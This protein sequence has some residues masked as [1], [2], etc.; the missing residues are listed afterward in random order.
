DEDETVTV[1]TGKVEIGQGIKTALAQIAAEE[2]DV[3]LARVQIVTA[4]TERTPDE[5]VTSGSRSLETSGEAI[6][7]AAAEA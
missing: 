7:Q 1:L 4:D 6:R 5:G 3:D 2:L